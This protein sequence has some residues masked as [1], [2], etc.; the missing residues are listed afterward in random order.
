MLW[1]REKEERREGRERWACDNVVKKWKERSGEKEVKGG[2]VTVSWKNG[3]WSQGRG[4]R[5]V[6][7]WQC[8]EKGKERRRKKERK[9]WAWKFYERNIMSSTF[10]WSLVTINYSLNLEQLQATDRYCASDTAPQSDLT[11][12]YAGSVSHLLAA[13]SI[14]PL[15]FQLSR[16]S[17]FPHFL[18]KMCIQ[19]AIKT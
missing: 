12:W 9:V 5:K 8:C 6:G 3:K 1:K 19:P 18:W 10:I 11:F 17:P 15:I 13:S 14:A 7:M 4:K 16:Y 2:H